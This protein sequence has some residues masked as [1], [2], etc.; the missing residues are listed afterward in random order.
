ALRAH[1]HTGEVEFATAATGGASALWW[2]ADGAHLI[3]AEPR[4]DGAPNRSAALADVPRDQRAPLAAIGAWDAG[5]GRCTGPL[6]PVTRPLALS[7]DGRLFAQ[8]PHT[9]LDVVA[10][11]NGTVVRSWPSLHAPVAATFDSAGERLAVVCGE[12]DPDEG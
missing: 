3:A 6:P 8:R 5:T 7:R 1:A 9:G 10:A 12:L 2:S 4:A 11:G